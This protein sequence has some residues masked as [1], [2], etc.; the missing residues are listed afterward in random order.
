M[1][2]VRILDAIRFTS[3]DHAPG[4]VVELDGDIAATW[5]NAG[6]AEMVREQDVETPEQAD[7]SAAPETTAARSRG[8]RPRRSG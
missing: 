1:A 6:L 5:C 3:Y 8:A 4:D 2:R 7:D